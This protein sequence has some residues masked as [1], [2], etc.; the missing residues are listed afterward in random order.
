M[1]KSHSPILYHFQLGD[2]EWNDCPNRNA[3]WGYWMDTFQGFESRYWNHT[4]QIERMEN[5]SETFAFT[6][7]GTLFVGLNL[8]GGMSFNDVEWSTRLSSQAAWTMDLIRRHVYTSN[9]TTATTAT[10]INNTA[11]NSSTSSLFGSVL[12]PSSTTTTPI[13][14]F[15]HANPLN[16]HDDFFIPLRGFIRDELADNVPVLYLSKCLLM[17]VCTMCLCFPPAVLCWTVM[18][19]RQVH[20]LLLNNFCAPLSFWCFRW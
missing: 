10:G 9:T 14:I 12:G 5:R 1:V 17:V 7:K 6:H 3:A 11:R 8:V 19:E 15:G 2:N 4:F 13:V 18:L 16:H 20:V